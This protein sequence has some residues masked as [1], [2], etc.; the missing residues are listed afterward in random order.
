M[1]TLLTAALLI[2]TVGV[3]ADIGQAAAPAQDDAWARNLAQWRADGDQRL[4][5]ERGWLS[6][7][8]RD[9]LTAGKYRIGSAPDSDVKLPRALSPAHLGTME[10]DGR[11]NH[12]D[13]NRV[14]RQR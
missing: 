14:G 13:V 3:F 10:Q 11:R 5:S 12:R 8:T 4:K 6:I 1:K 2:A 7:V 9:E